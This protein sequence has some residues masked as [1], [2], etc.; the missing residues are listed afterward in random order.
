MGLGL[1]S[2]GYGLYTGSQMMKLAK[3]QAARADPFGPYRSGYAQQLNDLM[4]NPTSVTSQPGYKF[5]LEQGEQGVSRAAAKQGLN[6]TPAESLAL[7]QYDQ[8]YAQS[9]YQNQVSTLSNLAGAGIPPTSGATALG[10]SIAGTQL[11]GSSLGNLGYMVGRNDQPGA[12]PG[13]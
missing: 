9:Y 12:P 7:K 13:A 4:A 10:G 3:E 1:L 8:N 11:I 5:G 2:T 6:L